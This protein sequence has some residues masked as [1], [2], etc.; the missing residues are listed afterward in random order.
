[1]QCKIVGSLELLGAGGPIELGGSKR[2]SLVA[3]LL[4]HHGRTRSLDRIVD[5]LWEGRGTAGAGATV[6]TYISQLRHRTTLKIERR[7]AGYVLELGP[8]DSLD[9]DDFERLVHAAADTGDPAARVKVAREALALWHGGALQEF[10]GARWADEIAAELSASRWRTIERLADALIELDRAPEAI[11][12]LEAALVEAPLDERFW[13]LLVMAHARDNHQAE[14]LRAIGRARTALGVELG[15]EIGPELRRLE[16]RVL[17]GDSSL[18][19]RPAMSADPARATTGLVTFL[20]TDIVDSTALWDLQPDVMSTAVLEHERLIAAAIA[21]AGGRVVKHRGEGDSTLSIFQ[22]ASDAVRAAAD[23]VHAAAARSW[24]VDPPVR[25]RVSVHTGEAEFR[26]GDYFGA[27]LSRGARLRALAGA[28]EVLCSLATAELVADSLPD[29][30]RLVKRGTQTLRGLRRAEVVYALTNGTTEPADLEFEILG[31]VTVGGTR[32]ESAQLRLLLTRLLV[33]RNA[34]VSDEHLV[35]ALWGSNAPPTARNSLQSKISRLRAIVGSDRLRRDADGYSLVTGAAG[36]DADRFEMLCRDA[37]SASSDVDAIGMLEEALELWHGPAYGEFTDVGFVRAETM[38]LEAARRS[39]EDLRLSLI[40][41]SSPDD[42]VAES[43]R[44][45]SRDPFR[46]SAWIVQLQ[47]LAAV[48]RR[49]EALRAFQVYRRRLAEETGLSPSPALLEIERALLDSDPIAPANARA[50]RPSVRSA[51][52]RAAEAGTTWTGPVRSDGSVAGR[53][54]ELAT[55][56]AALAG[57]AAARPRFIVL[58]GEAG[59]GKTRLLDATIEVATRRG[60]EVLRGSALTSGPAPLTAFRTAIHQIAPALASEIAATAHTNVEAERAQTVWDARALAFAEAVVDRARHRPVLLAVDDVQSLD[61]VGLTALELVHASIADA[62]Q[63]LSLVVVATH[64]SIGAPAEK[65]ARIDRLAR[66]TRAATLRLSG[67]DEPGL[68]Q[69]VAGATSVRPTAAL[70]D[71]LADAS[72]NP[73]ICLALLQTLADTRAIVVKEGRLD[74]VASAP[75]STPF[76]VRELLASLVRDLDATTSDACV[77]IALLGDGQRIDIVRR[78]LALDNQA[79]DDMLQ[80]AE[81]AGLLRVDAERVV[82]THDLLRWS[83]VQS[84]TGATRR[85]L[86]RELALVLEPYVDPDDAPMV[87]LLADQLRRS[88]DL[89]GDIRI[90]YWTALAGDHCLALAR[91]SDAIRYFDLASEAED[92]PRNDRPALVLKAGIAAFHHHDVHRAR[93]RLLDALEELESSGRTEELGTAALVLYRTAL[94]LSTDADHLTEARDTLLR[95]LDLTQGDPALAML[96]ARAHAQLAE[97]M[98]GVTDRDLRI[99]VIEAAQRAAHGFD[100][101]ELTSRLEMAVGLSALTDLELGQAVR[102]FDA[103]ASAAARIPDPLNETAALGRLAIA[104]MTGGSIGRARRVLNGL[105]E[106]QLG[107]RFW[108]ELAITEALVGALRLFDGD[109][110]GAIEALQDARGYVDRSGYHFATS[111]LYPTLVAAQVALGDDA[112]ALTAID[113]WRAA[114]PG[115][116]SLYETAVLS[117]CGDAA[118]ARK[119]VRSRPLRVVPADLINIFT[120]TSFVVVVR[121]ALALELTDALRDALA[122]L[123]ELV[124]RGVLATPSWPEFLPQLAADAAAVIGAPDAEDRALFAADAR[125]SLVED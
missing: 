106:R 18:A 90:G 50:S 123:D 29:G 104:F 75:S 92:T 111:V 102:S 62:S 15:V 8:D 69:L 98:W 42:A 101:D 2:R 82:F 124:G 19:P 34:T 53:E 80:Q 109:A 46:E 13:A 59:I 103:A 85:R 74:V 20:M 39:A 117:I 56:Q 22:L 120:M 96:R 54:T 122:T 49:V 41:Q 112:A 25:L 70:L 51:A 11:A 76:D 68:A 114:L 107:L 65:L 4:A 91:W 28:N 88:G 66:S 30:I 40:A 14:A 57:G 84:V 38:R 33:D 55:L 23:I 121:T 64:R 119:R 7:P 24:G 63:P 125:R 12:L 77:R 116:Q 48:G 78:V 21:A 6:Q 97:E 16:E 93:A 108:S 35:D 10:A 47:A 113:A 26:D 36:V 86:H 118:E 5:D 44:L 87:L 99:P 37:R 79:L 52:E 73:L 9:L 27:A 43:G 72:G 105:R 81:A 94:T 58:V 17:A 60:F 61:D 31:A 32:I 115:G 45:L 3:Y 89:G 95:F 110:V 83:L 1:L 100:D 67:L 71:A